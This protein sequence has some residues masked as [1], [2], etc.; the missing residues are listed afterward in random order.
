LEEITF[1]PKF[2][3][4]FYP[5]VWMGYF[6]L[7]GFLFLIQ[8]RSTN[9]FFYMFLCLIAL[10]IFYPTTT[11]SKITFLSDRLVISTFLRKN[12]V[13]PYSDLRWINVG[14]LN[15]RTGSLYL[16]PIINTGVL[17]QIFRDLIELGNIESDFL[18]RKPTGSEKW[19]GCLTVL[20]IFGILIVTLGLII[21]PYYQFIPNPPWWLPVV[22]PSIFL[23]SFI[24]GWI[25]FTLIRDT[26]NYL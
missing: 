23:Y 22:I 13:I 2:D 11:C 14:F 17:F 6:S 12:R 25:I 26:D 24:F 1:T 21:L 10:G 4:R 8:E 3:W 20:P 18:V 9:P 15:F 16:K 5:T 19:L 7:L